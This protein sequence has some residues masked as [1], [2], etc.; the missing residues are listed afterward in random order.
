[1]EAFVTYLIKANVALV[2]FYIFYKLIFNRDTFFNARRWYL[3]GAVLFS[4]LFPFIQSNKLGTLFSFNNTPTEVYGSVNIGEISSSVIVT[5]SVESTPFWLDWEMM[6]KIILLAIGII[7]VAKMLFQLALIIKIRCGSEQR[8]KYNITYQH[9]KSK[10]TPFSFFKWIFVYPEA[11]TDEKLRQILIHENVHAKQWHSVDIMLMELLMPLIWYN[12]FFWLLRKEV[13]I[14]IEFIA[15]QRV[16]GEGVNRREYQYHILHLT[17]PR[18]NIQLV[19]NFNVSQLKQRIMMMNKEKTP[20]RKLLKYTLVL[21]VALLLITANSVY[22]QTKEPQKANKSG[23]ITSMKIVK[24]DTVSSPLI[25]IDGVPMETDISLDDL[26]PEQIKSMTV[27]TDSSTISAYGVKAGR[28]VISI[29]TLGNDNKVA[30]STIEKDKPYIIIDGE[31]K[32]VDF[33]LSAISPSDIE[34][35]SVLK[36]KAE[37]T[38]IYGDEAKNGVLIIT[39][40]KAG[41]AVTSSNGKNKADN[42]DKVFVEVD[43]MP[44]FPGGHEAMFKFIAEQMKYPVEAQENGF[45]GRVI[46]NFVVKKDGSID[47]IQVVRGVAP[48]LD[49]EAVR[50]ISEMPKWTPGM[51]KGEKVNVQ[52]TMPLVFRL[53]GGEAKGTPVQEKEQS[54]IKATN[55]VDEVVA[56]ALDKSKS[57]AS[58]DELFMVVEEQPE[59]PGGTAAMMQFLSENVK[60][61]NIAQENGIQGRVI[62]N[63]VVEKDGSISDIQVVRGVDPALDVEA[64]RVIGTMPKW[65]PGKQRG[66]EVRVR[67][68]LPLEFRLPP[69]DEVKE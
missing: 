16:L 36:N 6:T 55:M 43:Q 44:V 51:N 5:D 45:Q 7:L 47:N 38:A 65:N 37:T 60:Y 53:Q 52:F 69:K 35:I 39:T 24:N 42:G 10:S 9:L 18:N 29:K 17:Y 23:K 11:H 13:A 33:D 22:A 34:S 63:F 14:N 50:V 15:D 31:K 20:M 12:P 46:C 61:P 25:V 41:S 30:K 26:N 2:I 19:N 27:F 1:M 66:Q 56:V 3:M 67:F 4:F 57:K 49:A 54:K 48:S 8:V 40:K 68:T 62:V 58:N 59:F 32:G 21:P 28:G 64:M